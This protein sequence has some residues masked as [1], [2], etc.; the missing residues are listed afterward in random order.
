M[1]LQ[2]GTDYMRNLQNQAAP[3][4]RQPLVSELAET[5]EQLWNAIRGL[6]EIATALCGSVPVESTKALQPV[7][8][9]LFDAVAAFRGT[10]EQAARAIEENVKRISARM[11]VEWNVPASM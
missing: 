6:D 7:D 1:A 4:A 8:N 5:R 3:S 11:P 10:V 2:Q 9:G